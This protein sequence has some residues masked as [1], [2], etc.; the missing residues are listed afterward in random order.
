MSVSPWAIGQ[1]NLQDESKLHIGAEIADPK[2][3]DKPVLAPSIRCNDL[4]QRSLNSLWKRFGK[5]EL[6]RRE[7]VQLGR[8]G[9]R[10]KHRQ[11]VF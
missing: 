3:R 5:A 6:E 4:R 1:G 7:R 8:R 10:I 2:F 9:R 11:W